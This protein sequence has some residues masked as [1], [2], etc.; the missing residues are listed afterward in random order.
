[1]CGS[2]V[3]CLSYATTSKIG[4]KSHLDWVGLEEGGDLSFGR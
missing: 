3:P 1:M 2:T 4:I